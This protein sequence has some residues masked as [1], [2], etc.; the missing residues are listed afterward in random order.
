MAEPVQDSQQLDTR[1]SISEPPLNLLFNPSLLVR[2]NKDI[3]SIDVVELLRLFLRLLE[4]SGNKDLRIC[5]VAALSS[6]MIYRLQVESIFALE[7]IAMQKQVNPVQEGDMPV[8]QLN[9]L[10]VPFRIEPSYPVSV[11]ELLKVLERMITE[12]ASPKQRKRQ[13]ELEPVQT[14][15]FDKYLVKFEQIIQGYEDM[16]FDI[17]S[18]DQSVRFSALVE[19]MD[20]IERARSFIAILYLALKGKVDLV[21]EE[22]PED[23]MVTIH[24]D[25]VSNALPSAEGSSD[26]AGENPPRS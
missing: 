12:L 19:K 22:I 16:I 21:Q 11:D 14:F 2:R 4:A 26:S 7:K 6:S 23:I 15:D 10:E 13:V 20:A 17:V 5:G 8:P 24:K 18:A 1:K 9:A 25:S 3:W